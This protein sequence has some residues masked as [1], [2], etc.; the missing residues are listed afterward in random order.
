VA[1][2]QQAKPGMT[3]RAVDAASGLALASNQ[4]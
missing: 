2:L 4:P 1:G 3:V